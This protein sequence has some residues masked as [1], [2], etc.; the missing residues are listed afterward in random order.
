MINL[1]DINFDSENLFKF[2]EFVLCFCVIMG[3]FLDFFERI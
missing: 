2:C 1:Q 3:V